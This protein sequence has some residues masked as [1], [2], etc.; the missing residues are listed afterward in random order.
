MK[1]STAL[2]PVSDHTTTTISVFSNQQAFEDAQRMAGLLTASDLVPAAFRGKQNLANAVIALEMAQ[3][4]GASPL[5]VMQNM[6]V[7]H[8]KPSWSAQFIAAAINSSGRFSPIR[9]QMTGEQNTD[10]RTCIAWATDQSGEKLEGPPVSIAMAKKEGWFGKNGSKWQ[11]MPELMLRYRAVTFFGRLYA[12][13]VLMGMRSTDE[14][15]ELP[16][17]EPGVFGS[18]PVTDINTRLRQEASNNGNIPSVRQMDE[19]EV[20]HDADC[21]LPENDIPFEEVSQQDTSN[22]NDAF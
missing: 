19:P 18:E 3:R 7:V 2:Q 15:I 1:E 22:F 16:E 20:Q 11:T 8:G 9:Y 13:E 6:Y 17:T 4:M 10:Q 21:E 5:A 12:P 14:V